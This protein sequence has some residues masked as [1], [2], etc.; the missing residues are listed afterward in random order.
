MVVLALAADEG[1]AMPTA[2][3]IRSALDH[4]DPTRDPHVYVL[5]IDMTAETTE[6][7]HESVA[8]PGVCITFIPVPADRFDHLPVRHLLTRTAYC[9]LLLPELLAG[10]DRVLYLDGDV[11][12]RHDVGPLFDLDLKGA[13]T[14]GARDHGLW[15]MS[16]RGGVAGA[17]DVPPDAPYVNTGVLVMDLKAW[18]ERRIAER[19]EALRAVTETPGELDQDSINVTIVGD[20]VLLDPRWNVQTPALIN[21]WAAGPWPYRVPDGELPCPFTAEEI[22][23]MRADPW[24]VHFT[25][26]R[27]PWEPASGNPY[28]REWRRVLEQ[29]SWWMSPPPSK[30]PAPAEIYRRAR[31]VAARLSRIGRGSAMV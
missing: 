30:L 19:V 29:T 28:Q 12:V 20:V 5:T 3:A 1:Y 15:Y 24:I 23:A 13:S 4:L 6:R 21:T 27:K 16:S 14:A 10:F 22:K 9:R 7:L 25:T 31:G 8:R 2:V 17:G 26:A 18:R 11:L